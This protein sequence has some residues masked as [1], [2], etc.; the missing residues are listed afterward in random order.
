[1]LR[2]GL[3]GVHEFPLVLSAGMVVGLGA[4]SAA[5]AVLSFDRSVR[6]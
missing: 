4:L 1:L 6:S 3:L 2:Y 5:V